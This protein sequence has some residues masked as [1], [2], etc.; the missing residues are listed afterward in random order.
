MAHSDGQGGMIGMVGNIVSYKRRD[1]DMMIMRG[2][3]RYSK[4]KFKTAASYE[5]CRQNSSEFGGR[6]RASRRIRNVLEPLKAV[7]DYNLA[8]VIAG[9][10]TIVQKMDLESGK[11][12][13]SVALSRLPGLLDGLQ[14]NRK[15]YLDTV[16][17]API[18]YQLSRE[19]L[20][21]QVLIPQLRV[22]DNFFPQK[23][24]SYFRILVTM[25]MVPDL[26][27]SPQD[28][29]DHPDSMAYTCSLWQSPWQLTARGM[30]AQQLKLEFDRSYELTLG[31]PRHPGFTLLLA[32]AISYGKPVAPDIIEPVRYVGAGKI[33]KGL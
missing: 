4:D 19:E 14:L 11:G 28:Y 2:R 13:R 33:L 24:F 31:Y 9:K 15:T 7:V 3:P 26:Y 32:M 1:I 21:A 17:A 30:E 6:S 27:W 16:L 23:G 25:G 20:T 18:E 22:H 12:K 8:P 29:V 5:P 10:V